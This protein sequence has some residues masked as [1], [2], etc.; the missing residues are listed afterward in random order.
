MFIIPGPS[1]PALF[2]TKL[3]LKTRIDPVW[4]IAPPEVSVMLMEAV[5]RRRGL[6]RSTKSLYN[7]TCS[8]S[9]NVYK[10][11]WVD[12]P[13]AAWLRHCLFI[14]RHRGIFTPHT[15][16]MKQLKQPPNILGYRLVQ[17]ERPTFP[18]SI[19]DAVSSSQTVKACTGVLWTPVISLQN[20]CTIFASD[21][22][23]FGMSRERFG[24]W[25]LNRRRR[26]KHTRD[27]LTLD[28]GLIEH[29]FILKG[30][31]LKTGV[32]SWTLSRKR[33]TVNNWRPSC[34]IFACFQHRID[35]CIFCILDP[36]QPAI[37]LSV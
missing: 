18:S 29:S 31:T 33:R 26:N 10:E 34:R 1:T 22:S 24:S 6:V 5:S 35:N 32:D 25:N 15:N 14:V 2:D 19:I 28:Q 4:K 17:A 16:L 27:S 21:Q 11:A 7:A 23:P 20:A 30:F 12:E 8:P 9:T 37:R 3:M 13:P 36:T